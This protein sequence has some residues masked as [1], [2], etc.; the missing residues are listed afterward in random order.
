MIGEKVSACSR[1]YEEEKNGCRSH[2]VVENKAWRK[3]LGQETLDS[4]VAQTEVSGY[5]GANIIA[6][7]L[8]LGNTCNLQCVMCQPRESSKWAA[9]TKTLVDNLE[10]DL[11]L[12]GEWQHKSNIKLELYEW[13]K[14]ERFWDNLKKLLP[15]MR[16]IIVGGGEPM[17]IKE[18]LKFIKFCARSGEA[19]HIHLRYHTN[20]TIMH[21]EMIPYWAKFQC[22]EMFVSID[23][24][25]EIANFIRYPTKWGDVENNLE[26]FDAMPE[27]VIL[28]FLISVSAL[29]IHH[30]PEFLVWVKNQRYQK[31]LSTIQAFVHPGFV[32]WPKYLNPKV[33]PKELKKQITSDLEKCFRDHFENES[34]D[35]YQGILNLMNSEDWSSKLPTMVNYL[36]ALDKS[37]KTD[38]KKVF[39]HFAKGLKVYD[40]LCVENVNA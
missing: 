5:L 17:L 20:A 36:K 35:K 18:H 33:L 12:K 29:N 30:L 26:I 32:H 34:M 23:G 38:Y 10:H 19:K 3:K 37:R 4:I 22:V 31:E 39:P 13:Y 21:P 9:G 24:I 15:H 16:E 40:Q 28:R 2:R 7:D 14:N 25:G 6:I 8:R 1:C 11:S 27:N